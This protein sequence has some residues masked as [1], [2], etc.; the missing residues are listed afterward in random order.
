MVTCECGAAAA[1]KEHYAICPLLQSIWQELLDAFGTIP[2][3]QNKK[4]TLDHILNSSLRFTTGLTRS[5][6]KTAWSELL[7]VFRKIDKLS[8]LNEDYDDDLPAPKEAL[9]G[10]I[11]EPTR[12]HT[13][14]G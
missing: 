13:L 10:S 4:Q 5:K 8:H 1:S 11:S 9:Q 12:N 7:H 3:L 2:E 6:W 14:Y